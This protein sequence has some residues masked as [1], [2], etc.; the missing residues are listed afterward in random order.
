MTLRWTF[1]RKK[2]KMIMN[3]KNKVKNVFVVFTAVLLSLSMILAVNPSGPDSVIP[4][5]SSTKQIESAKSVSVAGGN[6]SKFNL[7]ATIQNPRWKAFVGNVTGSFTLD[8]SSGAT[9]YDWSLA[10]VTGRVYT[11]R[12]TSTVTWGSIACASS[13]QIVSENTALAHTNINDNLTATFTDTNHPSFYIGDVSI[14]A[15][16]CRGLDTYVNNASQSSHFQEVVLTDTSNLVY[17]TILE[18]DSVGYD[19][20]TYDFQLLVPERGEAGNTQVTD[21]YLYV[22]IGND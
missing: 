16:T 15:N 22:E 14:G 18:E 13:A 3:K 21:Y 9:I 10:K 1:V 4:V 6:I 20:D 5:S 8:D 12:K 2:E 7:D 11:T 17:A 19:G